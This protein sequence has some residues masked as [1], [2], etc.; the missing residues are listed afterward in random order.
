MDD[1]EKL[2]DSSTKIEAIVRKVLHLKQLDP[3]VK[4][5]IFSQWTDILHTLKEEL[6]RNEILHRN[7]FGSFKDFHTI[8]QEFKVQL[9][10]SCF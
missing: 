2:T 6:L 1:G 4:I 7:I 8:V 5:L 9:L 3:K 10:P